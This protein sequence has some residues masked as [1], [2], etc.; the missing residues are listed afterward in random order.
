MARALKPLEQ[1][2]LTQLAA[3]PLL[4]RIELAA[5][6]G[7]STSAVYAGVGA[8]E[9]EGLVAQVPHASELI[10]LSR[11]FYLTAEGLER[12]SCLSGV[13]VPTLL[14]DHPASEQWL[15]SLIRRLAAVAVIY[16]LA[17]ALCEASFPLRLRWHRSALTDAAIA[18]PDGRTLAIVRWGRSADRTAFARRLNRLR[19]GA[20]YSAALLLVTDEFRLR[21]AR[22]LAAR[23]PFVCVLTLESRAATVERVAGWCV[24]SVQARIMVVS[25]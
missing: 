4:D 1:E 15:R 21:H 8:L 19:E 10:T 22:R 5:L 16:R 2:L 18:L 14:S 25:L 12:L 9:R 3:T 11:R 13:S 17:A 7:R 23:L 6:C 20:S 24:V